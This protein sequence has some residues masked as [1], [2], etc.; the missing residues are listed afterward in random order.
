M[1]RRQSTSTCSRSVHGCFT[2]WRRQ[3]RRGPARRRWVRCSGLPQREARS[4]W[5]NDLR[6]SQPRGSCSRSRTQWQPRTRPC[7]RRIRTFAGGSRAWLARRAGDRPL[8]PRVGDLEALPASAT[9]APSDHAWSRSHNRR[10]D[11]TDRIR[12]LVGASV[13]LPCDV[14]ALYFSDAAVALEA[15]LHAEFA[16]RRLDQVTLRREF[17]LQHST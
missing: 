15:Q 8:R 5:C 14:H 16:H 17:F 13:R 1:D 7:G 12:E 11:P 3:R 6:T 2:R 4:A 10:L 9:S